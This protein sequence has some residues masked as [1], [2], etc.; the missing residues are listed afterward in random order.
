MDITFVILE[1]QG[2]IETFDRTEFFADGIEYIISICWVECF[3]ENVG[4]SIEDL[5]NIWT[6]D[7]SQRARNMR[8]RVEKARIN[9]AHIICKNY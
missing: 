9:I 1:G 2:R 8:F 4:I 6:C 5:C 7:V 3:N